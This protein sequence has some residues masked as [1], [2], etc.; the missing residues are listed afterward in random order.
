[1]KRLHLVTILFS[2][3]LLLWSVV[4]GAIFVYASRDTVPPGVSINGLDIGSLKRDKAV[5]LVEEMILEMEQ[6]KV[7]VTVQQTKV[8]STW[9][10]LGVQYDASHFYNELDRLFE[11]S[12]WERAKARWH[13][14][15]PWE[16][17]VNL[18]EKKLRRLFTPQWE[19]GRFGSP[20][21][22]V[23]LISQADKIT[24]LPERSVS[25]IDWITFGAMIQQRS[26]KALH[27]ESMPDERT[28]QAK[29]GLPVLEV[30]LYTLRP[31]VTLESL[32][33][34]GIERKITEFT[35]G[36][37]GSGEGRRHNIEAAARTID[38]MVLAPGETF[39]YEQVIETAE[40]KYGFREAPVIFGGRLVPGVGG[41]ICQVS[42]TLY[43]AVILAGLD[44]V[45]R[46]NHTLPVSY[47]AKGLDATFARGYINFRFKNT[48]GRH[49]LIHSRVKDDQLTVKL[50]GNAPG[51][52]TYDVE[53]LTT[54]T[55]P[56]PTKY[57]ANPSLAPGT[58]EKI[59]EGKPGYIV[60]SYRIKKI[61]G[62]PVSK[63]KLSRDTYPPQPTV[64]AIAPENTG[65]TPAPSTPGSDGKAPKLLLED[66]VKGPSF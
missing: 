50:F 35:T 4:F 18:D 21:D 31:K 10:E 23:R 47:V 59:I 55:I 48:T 40:D 2:C 17:H 36:L 38:G 14:P 66:G 46:R 51:D 53:S 62:K 58:E 27:Q 29:Q 6:E 13:F 57:V 39:N 52:I 5:A 3:V 24:Y 16:L 65:N 37:H 30:P 45:E 41:G 60:E 22:A 34:Q 44:I 64:I 33:Q 19:Q 56:A 61:S 9:K 49:L 54:R 11:G 32:H 25:R 20:T 26:L 28:R 12:L 7:V 42:S 63:V 8:N 1:M 15:K 43:N